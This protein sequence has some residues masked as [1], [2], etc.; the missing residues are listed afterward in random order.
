MGMFRWFRDGKPLFF[1]LFTVEEEG[2]SLV[3]RIKHFHPGLRG[4]EEKD[5]SVTFDLTGLSASRVEWFMR[6]EKGPKWLI[7]KRD[8]TNLQGWFEKPEDSAHQSD[9]FNY[10]AL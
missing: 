3:L 9:R 10:T 1:E 4:W 2:D 7:Y 8:G 6:G 5:A